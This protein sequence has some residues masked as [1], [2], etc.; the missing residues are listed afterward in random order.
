MGE[1]TRENLEDAIAVMVAMFVMSLD[2]HFI[3]EAEETSK[4]SPCFKS[5]VGAIIVKR[6]EILTRGVN[7]PPKNQP[8]CQEIGWCYRLEN[9]IESGTQLDQC[10][11]F[12]SHAEQNAI[13]S[14]A[15]SG[16][17]TKGAT[18][19]VYGNTVICRGCRSAIINADIVMVIYKSKLGNIQ[20]INV[21]YDWSVNMLDQPRKLECMKKHTIIELVN[22]ESDVKFKID[23]GT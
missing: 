12:G 9:D 3:H 22:E 19:Y 1:K 5:R 13:C 4:K 8:T 15:S 20:K 10:R 2:E 7:E 14:A 6:G 18:M 17:A 16:I 23:D 11:A 21:T